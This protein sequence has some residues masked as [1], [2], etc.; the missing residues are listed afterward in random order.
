M[1]NYLGPGDTIE[2]TVAGS[3]VTAGQTF[4]LNDQFGVVV[5]DAAIGET[6]VLQIRGKVGPL[7]ATSAD[8]I[9]PGH[10]LYWDGVRLTLTAGTNDFAGIAASVSGVGSVQVDLV[11]ASPDQAGI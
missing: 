10:R 6:G 5:E 9:A 7:S 1:Q 4:L 3:A 11:L 8:D 2:W